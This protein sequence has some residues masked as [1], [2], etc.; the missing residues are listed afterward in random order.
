[1]VSADDMQPWEGCRESGEEKRKAD[2]TG[3]WAGLKK[4]ADSGAAGDKESIRPA[5]QA[6]VLARNKEIATSVTVRGY[7]PC[8]IALISLCCGSLLLLGTPRI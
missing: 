5:L 3:F 7:T 1:M 2:G 8:R 6:L 4:S